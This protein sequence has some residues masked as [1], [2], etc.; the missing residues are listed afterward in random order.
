MLIILGD[1]SIST[2]GKGLGLNYRGYN[3]EDL[4]KY[5]IFEEVAYLLLFNSL[6]T[7]E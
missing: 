4:S 5:C 2:V 3:I 6:P 1:S 7:K